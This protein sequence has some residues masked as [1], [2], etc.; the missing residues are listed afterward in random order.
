VVG[1]HLEGDRKI[2]SVGIVLAGRW[3]HGDAK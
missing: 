1:E 2:D 3:W